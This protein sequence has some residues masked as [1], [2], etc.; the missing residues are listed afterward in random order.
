MT[1]GGF[2]NRLATV[3]WYMSDVSGGGETNFPRA[4][5]GDDL[6]NPTNECG[7]RGNGGGAHAHV[8]DIYIL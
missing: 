2:L 3:F 6:P 1:Q 4:N 7:K 8:I 5:G